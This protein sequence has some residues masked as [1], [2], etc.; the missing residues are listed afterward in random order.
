MNKQIST[1]TEHIRILLS[2]NGGLLLSRVFEPAKNVKGAFWICSLAIV[3]LL[4]VP[5]RGN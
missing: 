2:L 3:A 5:H 4:S 1:N